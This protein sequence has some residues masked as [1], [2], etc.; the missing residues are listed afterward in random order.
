M[1]SQVGLATRR[2]KSL[3]ERGDALCDVFVVEKKNTWWLQGDEMSSVWLEHR[4]GGRGGQMS[5]ERR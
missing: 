1:M 5:Q 3:P 4:G 2:R